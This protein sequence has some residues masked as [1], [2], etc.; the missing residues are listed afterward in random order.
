M[1]FFQ[2]KSSQPWRAAAEYLNVGPDWVGKKIISKVGPPNEQC[3]KTFFFPKL[4]A[5]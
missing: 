4:A 1:F 5:E 3:N 2:K